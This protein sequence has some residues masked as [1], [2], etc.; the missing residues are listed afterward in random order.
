MK[1]DEGKP[2]VEALAGVASPLGVAISEADRDTMRMVAEA[3][4]WR[5]TRTA[6]PF[7]KG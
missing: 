3:V 1:P 4:F 6:W 7:T 5:V 2:K